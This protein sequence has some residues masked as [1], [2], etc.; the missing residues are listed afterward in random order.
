VPDRSARR[1]GTARRSAR[2]R[3]R[4]LLK[5]AGTV[6]REARVA[7]GLYQAVV[8]ERAGVSQS[9]WSRLE[10]GAAGS[11]ELETL[12]ACGAA[13]GLQL[14]AFYE[15]APGADQPRDIEH[16]KRQSYLIR[17]A[18]HGGW[19]AA[20]E[21]PLAGDGPR[22]RSI[23][24]LLSRAE[25]REAAVTEIWDL[26]LDV[27]DAMRGLDAK[28]LETARRLGPTWRVS[29]LLLLRRT[30]RNRALVRELAPLIGARFPASSSAWLRSLSDP[31]TPMPVGA[32]FAWT[33]VQGDRL[34]ATR[35]GPPQALSASRP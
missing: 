7:A 33:N 4:Y 27:G 6:L 22:P 2:D 16:A 10:R 26:L 31:A 28:V 25:R 15:R 18:A 8:A 11:V 9:Y 19:A 3:S 14:A 17:L 29:G 1:A 24:V 20:P 35:I 34:I 13:I 21:A 23:D 12:A 5:R 30:A 32:G